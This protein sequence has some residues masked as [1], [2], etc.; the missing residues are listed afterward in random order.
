MAWNSVFLLPGSK[1]DE[2]VEEIKQYEEEL[3]HAGWK[4]EASGPWP[5]YHFSSFS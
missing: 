2:F 3:G 4:I 1:V 5:P